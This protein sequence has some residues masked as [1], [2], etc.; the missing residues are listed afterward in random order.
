MDKKFLPS[1]PPKTTK[2]WAT[3]VQKNLGQELLKI[4]QFGHTVPRA[5]YWVHY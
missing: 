3:F 5:V 1:L 4:G 2:F